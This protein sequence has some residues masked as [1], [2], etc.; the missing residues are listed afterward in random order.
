M[1]AMVLAAGAGTRLRPLTDRMPKALVPVAGRPLLAWVVDRL[2][3]AGASR[4]IV[5]L[6]H[7]GDQ[8]RA[9]LEQQRIPGVEL[10]ISPETDGPYDTGGG[11]F[12]AAHLFRESGPF[13]LHNV[14]VISR[15]PLGELVAAHL[16]AKHR[17]EGR[18]VASLA[19]Q[20][21]EA[22]R[23]LLFDELGLMGWENRGS[24]RSTPDTHRVRDPASPLRRYAFTGI[25]VVEPSVFELSERTGTFSIITLYLEL[26]AR[27]SIVCP[28]DVSSQDWID[29]GTPERLAEAERML[30]GA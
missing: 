11:L 29:V 9:F 10:L 6:H 8:L 22:Q 12:A 19:V 23:R 26:A 24:E 5:N 4:I 25:H 27:G 3:A 2:V 18:L 16:A 20:R 1:E 14:D 17:L 15:I 21:R 7:H 28:V 30:S 13:L